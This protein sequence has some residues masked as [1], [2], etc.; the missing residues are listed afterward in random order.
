MRSVV[1]TV[2]GIALLAVLAPTATLAQPAS[3][4]PRVPIAEF[5]PLPAADVGAVPDD[6]AALRDELMGP[7]WRDPEAVTLSWTG[8]SSFVASIRGHVFLFD[9]WE[10]IGAVDDYLPLGREELAALAPEAILVGHGH[11]DHAGDLGYV[12]G[13]AGA[14][15]VG[16]EEHCVIAEEGAA[17][18]GVTMEEVTCAITGTATTPEMGVLQELN[19]WQDV[20]PITVMRHIHSAATEPG[21]DNQPDPFLPIMD[22]APY[23]EH[24]QDDPEELARFLG[25]QQESNEGGVWLY[26]L[27]HG[28]FT[29]LWG[30]SSGP[31]FETPDVVAALDTFPGCVDVMSNAILGFDQPVSG[32]QDPRLYVEAAHPQVFLPQHAD[33]WAPVISA[34][35]AQY[36]DA[37]EAEMATLD[38]PPELDFLLDPDD[39]LATRTYDVTDPRWDQPMPGSS[40]AADA[41]A[42]A[43]ATS[44]AAD[45]T[46]D[47]PA[48]PTLPAT[49]GGIAAAGLVLLAL[50]NRRRR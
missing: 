41:D 40:C 38:N 14:V 22:P 5:T 12:A 36:V 8:V 39:Y 4:P 17:R 49:G 47:G 24:F 21:E 32:L 28:D 48:G 23:V 31:I 33:A 2:A 37:F 11:F 9:A 29:L 19:L 50:A 16:S 43:P 18:E 13:R 20:E 42:P 6:V 1:L 27:R 3:G 35:Q 44:P 10:I 34:G 46:G 26:H 30:N 15:I 45:G 25:Q 7:G